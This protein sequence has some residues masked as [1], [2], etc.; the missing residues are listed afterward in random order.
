MGVNSRDVGRERAPDEEDED[1]ALPGGTARATVKPAF[2]VDQY[3]ESVTGR[4]R[5]PT[6]I[7]EA[8]TEEARLASVLMDSTPPSSIGSY[9]TVV[10]SGDF[11]SGDPLSESQQVVFFR[12]R[13]APM[14]R[15]PSLVRSITELGSVIADP[16]TAYILGFVD[17]VLPLETIVEVAGLP[18]LD[19]LRI[20][21]RAVEQVVVTFRSGR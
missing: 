5:M 10:P 8:A 13:L 6:I 9:A 4:E 16:K 15:A 12:A 2:D 21:D 14:S 18:E 3:A 17:G 11:G 7:D 20:L 19:V 1:D